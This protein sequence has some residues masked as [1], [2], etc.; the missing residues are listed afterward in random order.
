MKKKFVT[1]YSRSPIEIGKPTFQC[2]S[3]DK[4]AKS[5]GKDCEISTIFNRLTRGENVPRVKVVYD[6]GFINHNSLVDAHDTLCRAKD[7]FEHLPAEV[8]AQY[9]NDLFKFAKAFT[10]QEDSI[11]NNG[12]L[13]KPVQEIK[14]P[15]VASSDNNSGASESTSAD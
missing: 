3:E 2:T 8:K 14:T 4:T 5:L 9:G 7:Y 13:K 12:I 10:N 15:S 11:F 6:E 1:Q